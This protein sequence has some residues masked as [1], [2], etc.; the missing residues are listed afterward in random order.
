MLG[1]VADDLTDFWP[2]VVT[3]L[4]RQ[5]NSLC[6]MI[7]GLCCQKQVSQA[8]I[9][10]YI[11]QFTV[12]CNYLHAPLRRLA[13]KT[14]LWNKFNAN[15]GQHSSEQALGQS[16]KCHICEAY[17]HWL[18]PCSAIDAKCTQVKL[19]SFYSQAKHDA[20]SN[21]IY[22]GYI[23][24]TWCIFIDTGQNEDSNGSNGFDARHIIAINFL[25]M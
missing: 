15:G 11:P 12:G 14:L 2:S 17:S 16:G 5:H 24:Y 19:R 21:Y 8:G 23:V 22:Q 18:G 3:V 9:S 20:Y 13:I 25:L 6:P 4:I 10:N 7:R 1:V